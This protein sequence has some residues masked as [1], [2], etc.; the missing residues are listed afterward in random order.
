MGN[1]LLEYG[2][3]VARLGRERVLILEEGGVNLPSDVLGMTTAFFPAEA[4][5]ARNAA[6]AVFVEEAKRDACSFL[7]N[8]LVWSCRRIEITESCSDNYRNMKN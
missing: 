4:G 8:L 6:L 7:I 1:V 5:A 3:F 2:I